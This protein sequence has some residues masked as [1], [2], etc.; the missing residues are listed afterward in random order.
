MASVAL[1]KGLASRSKVRKAK[2]DRRAIGSTLGF[3]PAR[4]AGGI[5]RTKPPLALEPVDPRDRIKI[6][7]GNVIDALTRVVA[8]IALYVAAD[9]RKSNIQKDNPANKQTGEHGQNPQP[10]SRGSMPAQ[11]SGSVEPY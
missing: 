8:D 10:F 4:R 7:S 2:V 1:P 6:L 9:E 5:F 11:P 3:P